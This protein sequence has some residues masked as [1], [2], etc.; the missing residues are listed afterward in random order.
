MDLLGE[1]IQRP[2]LGREDGSAGARDRETSGAQDR[3]SPA[4]FEEHQTSARE[5]VEARAQSEE[6][7]AAVGTVRER[8]SEAVLL[9]VLASCELDQDEGVDVAAG[10]AD[11]ARSRV[12]RPTGQSRQEAAPAGRSGNPLSHSKRERVSVEL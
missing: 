11:A 10:G 4:P 9:E 8:R 12:P 5:A 2:R 7:D 6:A 3:A 1:E